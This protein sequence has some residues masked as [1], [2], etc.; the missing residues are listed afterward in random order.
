MSLPHQGEVYER[1]VVGGGCRFLRL[2]TGWQRWNSFSAAR[3]WEYDLWFVVPLW[4][5]VGL[6]RIRGE[7]T[8]TSLCYLKKDQHL[9]DAFSPHPPPLR[10]NPH[11]VL[12]LESDS[13]LTNFIHGCYPRRLMKNCL[14]FGDGFCGWPGRPAKGFAKGWDR[15][16]TRFC[17]RLGRTIDEK[18][19]ASGRNPYG[20]LINSITLWKSFILRSWRDEIPLIWGLTGRLLTIPIMWSNLENYLKFRYNC[21]K[22]S[23]FSYLGWS[24]PPFKDSIK[25]FYFHQLEN[26]SLLY[27]TW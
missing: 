7:T 11:C 13:N 12:R 4:D 17:A 26:R 6:R 3:G 8:T 5:Q 18:I 22:E 14:H 16:D 24:R 2:Q 9:A 19:T 27:P 20:F 1:R 10:W 15:R 21:L 25:L 23:N